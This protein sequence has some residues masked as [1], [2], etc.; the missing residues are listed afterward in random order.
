MN[1]YLKYGLL[2]IA[3]V[4]LGFAVY[5]FV[6]TSKNE[7][8]HSHE[9]AVYTCPMHPEIIRNA[10][11][12]CPIC[13]MDL[14]KKTVEEEKSQSP[15]V[16][17]LLQP[18]N[19]FVTGNFKTARAKDTAISSE[20]KLPGIVTYDANSYE[21]IAARV[22]GRIE[23]MYVNYAYQKVTKG[24]KLFDLYSPEL[25]TEQQNF[26]YLIHNDSENKPIINALKQKLLLYGMTKNQINSLVTTQR[27]NPII[28]IYSPV[29]GVVSGSK[30]NTTNDGMKTTAASGVSLLK[31]GDYITKNTVVFQLVSTDKVWGVFN[32]IQ[33]YAS[34]IKMGQPIQI[35]SE[36]DPDE[37][38]NAKVDFVE[39]Q[40]NPTEKT[41]RIRV[42][43]NNA[44]RQFPIG[45]RLEG[46]I[47]T[48]SQ[49]GIWLPKQA[50]VSLGSHQLVF[51]KKGNGFQSTKVKT[52]IERKGWIQILSGISTEEEVAENGYYLMDSESFI[53]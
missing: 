12:Q 50:L 41:N 26:L 45:L 48:L 34:Q 20:L 42:Y 19:Q 23:K 36:L 38:V 6:G 32:V 9:E 14:V 31:E 35:V 51:V 17:E 33:G 22:N 43:L 18:A 13:G 27:V 4:L 11:G 10:P 52:G 29:S 7:S 2:A 5:Y 47:E 30:S 25:L 16:E 40:L 37:V 24:Q 3:V 15:D 46:K 44:Q 1:N 39:T 21:N 53:R 49:K 8:A 28:S